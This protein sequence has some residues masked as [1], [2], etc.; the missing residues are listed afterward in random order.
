MSETF[1]PDQS[2]KYTIIKDPNALLDYTFNWTAWLAGVVDKI[3]TVDFNVSNSA[4]AIVQQTYFSDT[5]AT[6]WVSGGVVGEKITLRCRIYT[7]E[8]RIDDRTGYLKV[9]ER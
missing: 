3:I 6:A 1:V 7:E 9:K 4:T 8:G 2:G 5:H